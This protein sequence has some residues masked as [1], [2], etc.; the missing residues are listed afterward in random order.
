MH[1]A[2]TFIQRACDNDMAGFG[3]FGE[4]ALVRR[5][6]SAGFRTV[7]DVG[8][9]LGDWTARVL[10][11][12][13][14]ATVHAFEISPST[15]ARLKTRFRENADVV[16]NDFGLSSSPGEGAMYHYP[17]TPDVTCDR[18]RHPGR[19]MPFMGQFSTVDEY[20]LQNDIGDVD[21]LKIDVEGTEH[22]VLRGC[23]DLIASGRAHCVQFEYG[24]FSIDT[25]FLLADYYGLLKER[26]WIGKILPETV[27]F[28]DYTWALE[29][30]RFS[31]YL[32]ISKD[33]DDLR[34]LAVGRTEHSS[35]GA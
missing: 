19:V 5:L 15:A 7:F 34:R 11:A 35:H 16:V 31:N 24:A 9:N 20:C 17:D 33:R 26:Y 6:S 13:P 21:F 1:S 4:D 12:W 14:Q 23:A 2:A 27:D 22:L 25:R 29:T 10:H 8:A 3:D 30:F 32:C 18:P 28:C